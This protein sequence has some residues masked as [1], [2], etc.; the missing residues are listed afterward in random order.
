MK[1]WPGTLVRAA[2]RHPGRAALLLL[3]VGL[4][5]LGGS[6]YG[7]GYWH[8]R[9]ARQ[10]LDAADPGRGRT[11]LAHCLRVWPRSAAT[12]LLAAQAARRDGACSEAERHL[13]ACRQLH[14]PPAA[15]AREQ[16]LLH[17]QQGDLADDEAYLLQAAASGGAEAVLILEA[18]TQGYLRT[19][20]MADASR[21]VESLLRHR[22]NHVDG[23]LWR[24][25][26]LE[27]LNRFDAALED[28]R[29]AVSLRPDSVA[30]RLSVGEVLLHRNHFAE[31][32]E[33]FALLRRH[34]PD[35]VAVLLGLARCRRGLGQLE[36]ARR[37]LAEVS[38]AAAAEPLVLREKGLLALAEGRPA[39]AERWLR[40]PAALAVDDREGRYAL[41]Q[42]LART[43]RTDEARRCRADLDRLEAD[44][45]R[46]I[47]LRRGA[48]RARLAAAQRCEAG[49]LCLRLGH[50]AEGVRWLHS[51]LQEAPGHRDAHQALAR[52]Y[53]RVGKPDLA[54]RHFRAA[55]A[56]LPLP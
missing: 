1:H 24:G 43:G 7:W 51:A 15:V 6:W 44:L 12:H 2:R 14:A 22:P 50:D 20:R 37:L 55:E 31:A 28:Y 33:H 45:K 17:V 34:L 11:H 54:A 46:L 18:L 36:Q 29:K 5:G 40:S 13:K 19:R 3:L 21:C 16:V 26:V 10:A 27:H 38:T 49:V 35:N 4:G 8:W 41:Y 23:L 52:Y 47:E 9:A 25:Q 30:A 32:A 56:P 48:V 42:C 53:H 39:E